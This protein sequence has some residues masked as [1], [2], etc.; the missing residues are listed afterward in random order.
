[1]N[2]TGSPDLTLHEVN[3]ATTVI[4][5]ASGSDANI[6]FGAVIDGNLTNEIRVTV[7][8]TG[9]GDHQRE[10][11]EREQFEKASENADLFQPVIERL[12]PALPRIAAMHDDV[13]PHEFVSGEGEEPTEEDLEIPAFMRN[14]TRLG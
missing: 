13:K 4:Y 11:E 3:E 2:I 14:R 12:Q 5:D 9:F 10:K 8:A 1:M 6:I 7:I